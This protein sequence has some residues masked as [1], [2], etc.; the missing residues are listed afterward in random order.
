MFTAAK[1]DVKR[2]HRELLAAFETPEGRL[3]YLQR[4]H[5]EL[6]K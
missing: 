6:I 2:E 5:E 4:T 1:L 3:D